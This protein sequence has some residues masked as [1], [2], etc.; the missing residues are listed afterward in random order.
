MKDE[1]KP[2][3]QLIGELDGR[4]EKVAGVDA[5]AVERQLAVERVR[6]A[7]MEMRAVLG[8][9]WGR[10]AYNWWIPV[11]VACLLFR[12]AAVTAD[13][14]VL[15]RLMFKI[16]PDRMV[17]FTRLYKSDLRPLLLEAGMRESSEVSRPTEPGWFCRLFEFES[18]SQFEQLVDY[19]SPE[20][21]GRPVIL[22]SGAG[23][24]R[25]VD[26][27][28][29][30][31]AH[32]DDFHSADDR[33][34][35][36]QMRFQFYS[37]PMPEARPVKTDPGRVRWERHDAGTGLE[38]SSLSG[39][40]AERDGSIW[41]FSDHFVWS[42][43]DGQR[44]Q[45]TSIPGLAGNWRH[46]LSDTKGNHWFCHVGPAAKWASW[47][48]GDE[49][50]RWDEAS[51]TVFS[52]QDA[53][54]S[55]IWSGLEDARG[56]VW[57]NTDSGAVRF[58]GQ[59]FA[60]P[61][62]V[63]GRTVSVW[64]AGPDQ[65]VWLMDQVQGT[66][67]RY[68]DAITDRFDVRQIPWFVDDSGLPFMLPILRDASGVLWF[69]TRDGLYTFD[70]ERFSASGLF[71]GRGV[72]PRLLDSRGDLWVTTWPEGWLYRIQH[73]SDSYRRQVSRYTTLDGLTGN[74]ISHAIEDV[75]GSVW[76]AT[77]GGVSR[78]D[79]ALW[80]LT[81][82]EGLFSD[83]IT[84]MT[85]D[86]EGRLW[87]TTRERT[88]GSLDAAG[89][90][91]IPGFP[92]G[93]AM[94]A[95]PDGGLLINGVG[96]FGSSTLS[97]V[98]DGRVSGFGPPDG[99]AGG[100]GGH[101]AGAILDR[102]GTAWFARIGGTVSYD[103]RSF[104]THTDAAGSK[105]GLDEDR[106]G[107]IWS[108]ADEF[109]V[110]CLEDGRLVPLHDAEGH[111]DD[112]DIWAVQED[113]DGDLWFGTYG[114][115]LLRYDGESITPYTDADGLICP[116]FMP[117]SLLDSR[118]HLWFGTDGGGAIR[119][120]GR[121]FQSLTRD[122]GLA[123]NVIRSIVEDEQGN[124]WLGCSGGLSR[125]TS[126]PAT[127]P[128]VF[129]DAVVA[130]QRYDSPEAVS[131]ASSSAFIAF[132][133]H[134]Q[135]H[136]TRPGAMVYR[137]RL[138]GFDD[139]W[140]VTRDQRVEYEGPPRGDFTF[141]VKAVDRDLNY[142][143]EPATVTLT[144]H[145]PYERIGLVSA[146]SLAVLLVVGQTGR[147]LRRDRRLRRA[148]RELSEANRTIQETTRNKSVFLSRMSHDLRT[149]MNAIIG[150]TR[151]LTR[152]LKGAIEDRQFRNLENIQIS[153]DSLLSL[154]NE[155]LDLSRIEAG[156][157]DLEPEVVDLGELVGECITSVAPLVRPEVELVPDMDDVP[158]IN[159]DADRIRRV[160]MNLLGNA[161]K[162]T[163]EGSITVSL[164]AMDEGCELSVAD[165]GVGI[166]AEDLP[167]IFEDF[168][169]VERQV[170]EKVE[171]T[172]LGLAIAKKSVDILG[173]TISAESEVGRGTT[174]ALRIRDYE[175]A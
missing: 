19:D 87:M 86:Q 129:L 2:K 54:P 36:L 15:A 123:G 31:Q 150:Y 50:A 32:A 80:T 72:I 13:E 40:F 44:W 163:E 63:E 92:A 73:A 131:V 61:L 14:P 158:P 104:R 149:P 45:T 151:I 52:G 101:L 66:I 28:P 144:V 84:K 26:L 143:E 88:L 29:W 17:E 110:A 68:E 127:A 94:V 116:L 9:L 168:H 46:L 4:C 121:T 172:G 76:V 74:I 22:L 43:F 57:M 125:Y 58:D 124:I 1:R 6:A 81:S 133:F 11:S 165:T 152:R 135:S 93:G 153:A 23:G 161:V 12:P 111:L 41:V 157:I 71:A 164:K 100:I 117:A 34:S 49:L 8:A 136:K 156:R 82:A 134:G 106:A 99:V 7:A 35:T 53:L 55:G 96:T 108:A 10:C 115:G 105:Y 114:D 25:T 24:S 42:R 166:P 16:R 97:L 67:F 174:F 173:G 170:G 60:P 37:A 140:R 5:P 119:T 39:V 103:G 146:L 145:W 56:T 70:G 137:Y 27:G 79:P 120:D 98:S 138:V 48:P 51:T 78:F 142:S 109:G 175:P 18:F 139:E 95:L 171:G 148:N 75:E 169:Q 65:P 62:R 154:I 90:A 47:A 130:D 59:S 102:A 77:N 159:T 85:F 33:G 89:S 132:E 3:K 21:S 113:G 112:V 20:L 155:I 122:D 107:R 128:P 162:F 167:H 38:H 147:V 160:V 69:G 141:E 30:L 83:E 64:S 91:L 118:G 126:P